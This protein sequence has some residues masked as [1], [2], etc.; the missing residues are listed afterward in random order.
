MGISG[1]AAKLRYIR[2]NLHVSYPASTPTF[3]TS[4]SPEDRREPSEKL[5]I[6]AH[7]SFTFALPHSV[8]FASVPGCERHFARECGL[9]VGK[10]WKDRVTEC[11]LIPVRFVLQC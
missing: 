1:S 4:D 9:E 11:E 7:V 5:V 10:H 2:E 8:I 6:G 3:G